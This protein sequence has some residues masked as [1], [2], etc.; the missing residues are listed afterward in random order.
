[1]QK[2]IVGTMYNVCWARVVA[3]EHMSIWMSILLHLRFSKKKKRRRKNEKKKLTEP[4]TYERFCFCSW[5]SQAFLE[6]LQ[7]RLPYSQPG[8]IYTHTHTYSFPICALYI[9]FS[10]AGH[11]FVRFLLLF[12]NLGIYLFAH[13]FSLSVFKHV[14]FLFSCSFAV[15]S[16]RLCRKRAIR[17][18]FTSQNE[19]TH[20]R[21]LCL[22]FRAVRFRM[23]ESFFLSLTPLFG[24][25]FH[26]I[27][28]LIH[29]SFIRKCEF[30]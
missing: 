1:M 13:S 11:I 21:T 24:I 18:I 27:T 3:H 9:P 25:R 6:F 2:H 5:F 12:N 8:H 7:L 20:V 10:N 22:S 14:S 19:V 29:V 23:F 28:P 26:N 4:E 15:D 30:I 16:M 17:L